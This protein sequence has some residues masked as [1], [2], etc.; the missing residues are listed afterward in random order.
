VSRLIAAVAVSAAAL[1]GGPSLALAAADT[2]RLT[3]VQTKFS[4]TRTGFNFEES[5]LSGRT[6]VGTDRAVCTTAGN[7]ARCRVTLALPRGRLVVDAML[8]QDAS[9]GPII[10][11]GGT[12]AYAGAAGSGTHTSLGNR[13][14][15]LV[16]RLR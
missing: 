4:V 11:A 2:V 5:L 12:R 7:T 14:T 6:K 3:A 15:G 10:V 16:I 1:A 8:T 13:R 9:S